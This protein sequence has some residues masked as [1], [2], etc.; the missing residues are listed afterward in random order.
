MNPPKYTLRVKKADNHL[1]IHLNGAKIYEKKTNGNP[2]LNDE[3]DI[4]DE[5][6]PH[7]TNNILISHGYNFPPDREDAYNPWEFHY[8]VFKDD[9]RMLDVHIISEGHDTEG[10]KI[11]LS[12]NIVKERP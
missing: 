9:A 8:Q 1:I 7:P 10:L 6:N 4:T 2:D 12:H 3:V 11:N 5:L